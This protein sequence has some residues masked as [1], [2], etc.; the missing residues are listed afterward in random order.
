MSYHII[1]AIV[2]KQIKDTFKNY[3]IFIQ[4]VMFPIISIVMSLSVEIAEIP[5]QY[6]VVLFA[7]MYVGMAPIVIISNIIAEEKEKGTLKMLMMSNVKPLEYILG[8]SFFVVIGCTLGLIVMG[9]TGGYQGYDLLSFVAIC[10]LAM[11]ASV[12]LGGIIGVISKDQSSANSLA[13]PAMLICSFIPM[14]S[15]FNEHIKR[16]GGFIY[17]QQINEMLNRIPLSTFP[18]EHLAIIF[19][20]I[21]VFIVIYFK[22]FLSKR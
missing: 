12:I 22:V 10:F 6:F 3:T 20:N 13:V 8:V 5:S 17:T 11:I 14:L 9:V 16:F 15:M 18:T 2:I 4:F 7:T 19:I 21:F 1:K